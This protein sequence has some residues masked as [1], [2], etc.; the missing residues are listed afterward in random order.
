MILASV[1]LVLS[2]VGVGMGAQGT[3]TTTASASVNEFAS[4][5]LSNDPVQFINADPGVP[6]TA[7]VGNGYPLTATIGSETNVGSIYVKTKANGAN[8]VCA[9]G[10]CEVGVDS[11]AVGS[12]EWNSAASWPGTIYT[13]SDATVCSG[14][15][16]DDTCDIYHRLTVPGATTAGTYEVG[17]TVTATTVA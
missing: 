5:S 6:K 9:S 8:F 12:M 3:D 16:A 13:V 1:L 10:G 17:I 2:I 7:E 11:F 15:G 4:V 14:K